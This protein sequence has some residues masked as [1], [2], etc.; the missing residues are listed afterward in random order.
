MSKTLTYEGV[1]ASIESARVEIEKAC[2]K[3]NA[4]YQEFF[5]NC[6]G[7]DYKRGDI[8]VFPKRRMATYNHFA[9]KLPDDLMRQIKLDNLDVVKE[10]IVLNGDYLPKHD[11]TQ[12]IPPRLYNA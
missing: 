8:V 2:E 5:K 6:F 12:L 11:F 3:R 7:A 10:P 9:S 4:Q 1:I